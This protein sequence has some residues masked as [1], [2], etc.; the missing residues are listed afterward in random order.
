MSLFSCQVPKFYHNFFRF[1]IVT[2]LISITCISTQN[3]IGIDWA[4][5]DSIHL[6]GWI[7]IA[8]LHLVDSLK[9]FGMGAI[10]GFVLIRSPIIILPVNFPKMWLQNLPN[11][12]RGISLKFHHNDCV[13]YSYEKNGE[14]ISNTGFPF[15]SRSWLTKTI[16]FSDCI[17]TK[18][19]K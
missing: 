15:H 17:T 19:S 7:M 12:P 6:L 1:S 3:E 4:E 9:T 14:L 2:E 16:Y 10:M 13:T 11:A 18:S 5:I 8:D